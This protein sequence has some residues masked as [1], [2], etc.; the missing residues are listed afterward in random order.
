MKKCWICGNEATTGEHRVKASDLRLIFGHFSPKKPIFY[1]TDKRINQKISGIG[2][3]RLQSFALI[4]SQCNNERTQSYDFA[5]EK[6]S[7][8]IRS[9]YPF[10]CSGEKIYLQKIFPGSVARSMLRIHLFFVKLFGCII[11][12]NNIAIDIKHFSESILSETAHPN[13]FLAICPSIDRYRTNSVGYSDLR[14]VK[15]GGHVVYAVCFYILDKI[16]VRVVFSKPG[17][18]RKG[19]I[20]TWHPSQIKKCLRIVK[21]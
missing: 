3:N 2:S 4:C 1:H 5:W 9:R 13:L 18:H 7:S 17:Q 6:F 14:I 10:I 16:C 20:G 21:P 15:K 19:L 8:F 11:V 12:E